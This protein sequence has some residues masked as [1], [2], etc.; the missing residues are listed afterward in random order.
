M[1][2]PRSGC[3]GGGVGVEPWPSG[4]SIARPLLSSVTLKG[5][6]GQRE[7]RMGG[8]LYVGIA[9]AVATADSPVSGSKG[10]KGVTVTDCVLANNTAQLGGGIA[11]GS[12]SNTSLAEI[13]EEAEE[14][15][16]VSIGGKSVI[17]GNQ[18]T[19][20]GGIWAS[21]ARVSIVRGGVIVKD[22]VAGGVKERC[23]E[24][25]G[26]VGFMKYI[27]VN[28]DSRSQKYMQWKLL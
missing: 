14:A 10:Y 8:G 15:G 2:L 11:V 28:I 19:S 13:S 1:M 26:M 4:D 22:N 7:C 20:G 16:A 21:D 6:G 5:N 24:E 18:A 27:K 25:V 23:K 17:S 12:F 3:P 9:T